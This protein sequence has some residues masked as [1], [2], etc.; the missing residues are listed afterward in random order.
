HKRVY[1]VMREHH[2][3]LRRPG[4]RRDKRRHDGTTQQQMVLTHDPIHA[5]VVDARCAAV[6]RW[7][8]HRASTTSAC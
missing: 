7:S 4:V 8:A 2:L 3:L 6:A 1:R 5:L